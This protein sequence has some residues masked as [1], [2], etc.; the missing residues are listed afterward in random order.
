MSCYDLGAIEHHV[1]PRGVIGQSDANESRYDQKHNGGHG[2]YIA[3][4]T[5]GTIYLLARK[6]HKPGFDH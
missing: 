6:T 4:S 3:M 5:G 2:D 1:N